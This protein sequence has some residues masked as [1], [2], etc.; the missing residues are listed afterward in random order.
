MMYHALK[1][2]SEFGLTGCATNSQTSSSNPSSSNVE[3][4]LSHTALIAQLSDSL[5][6]VFE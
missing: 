1:A 3:V 4:P 2:F 6:A 5:K